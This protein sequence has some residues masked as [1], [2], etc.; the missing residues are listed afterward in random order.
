MTGSS[1]ESRGARMVPLASG[2]CWMLRVREHSDLRELLTPL[3]SR[4]GGVV[5][6]MNERGNGAGQ[7]CFLQR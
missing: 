5:A 3:A 2:H 6:G 1:M 4:N 7:G